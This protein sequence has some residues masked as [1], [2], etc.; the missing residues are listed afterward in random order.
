MSKLPRILGLL[1]LGSLAGGYFWLRAGVESVEPEPDTVSVRRETLDRTVSATGVIRPMVGAEID[2]GSR[3]SGIVRS[4]PVKVGNPVARGDLLALIDATEF[5]AELDQ[6]RADLTLTEA[7]LS[8][9]RSSYRREARLAAEGVVSETQ[10]DVAARDL[11]VARAR[12]A[13]EQARVNSAEIRLGYTAA[14]ALRLGLVP[15]I[16][17]LILD[18]PHRE[19]AERI[20]G[21]PADEIIERWAEVAY[22]V[23]DRADQARALLEPPSS[24]P[25]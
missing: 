15:Q 5:E 13:L 19:R 10:L 4:I 18:R 1:L 22:F 3:V 23:L 12:V 6:A 8:L 2:V 14:V 16:L 17:G 11:Q 20:W 24:A 25:A 9:A 21:R 7:E